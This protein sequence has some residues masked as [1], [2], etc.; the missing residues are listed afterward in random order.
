MEKHVTIGVMSSLRFTHI[1]PLNGRLGIEWSCLKK[2]DIMVDKKMTRNRVVAFVTFLGWR[3]PKEDTLGGLKIQLGALVRM[4]M[5][6]GSA[7]K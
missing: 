7:A 2:S 5:H 6:K 1:L 3:I 4:D